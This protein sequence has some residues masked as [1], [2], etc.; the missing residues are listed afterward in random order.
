MEINQPSK[1]KYK[2]TPVVRWVA[3]IIFLLIALGLISLPIIQIWLPFVPDPT[4]LAYT[5]Y[6]VLRY[7]GLTLYTLIF[8]QIMSGAFRRPL[9][10]FLHPL[11]HHRW[12]IL[13]GFLVM[14]LAL[15]H[16]A[17]LYLSNKLI[18]GTY[19]YLDNGPRFNFGLLLGELQVALISAGFLSAILMN[20]FKRWMSFWRKIH[21]LMYV[22]FFSATVHSYILGSD[23]NTGWYSS[24]RWGMVSLVTLAVIWRLYEYNRLQKGRS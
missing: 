2:P 21:W 17:F 22:A 14:T 6:T 4:D 1:Q 16:P 23:I 15:A 12:H 19:V 24:V 5:E 20:F 18:Y 9:N 7:L 11:L 8:L 3:S 10:T 13:V